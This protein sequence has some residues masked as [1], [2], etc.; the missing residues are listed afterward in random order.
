MNVSSSICNLHQKHR[1]H[2]V[3]RLSG[4]N[5]QYVQYKKMP[6]CPQTLD[7]TLQKVRLLFQ[8]QTTVTSPVSSL[9]HTFTVSL[10]L[11]EQ[12]VSV[13]RHVSVIH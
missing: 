9:G 6:M 5:V 13:C 4:I 7:N 3:S 12:L 1:Q 2:N 11:G 10:R 8:R